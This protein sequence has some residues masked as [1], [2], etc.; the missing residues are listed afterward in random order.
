MRRAQARRPWAT[1]RPHRA[2]G[3]SRGPG[4]RSGVSGCRGGNMQRGAAAPLP[5]L[6]PE[7]ARAAEVFREE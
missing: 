6:A 3:L 2:D 1:P 4:R 7:A 5:S